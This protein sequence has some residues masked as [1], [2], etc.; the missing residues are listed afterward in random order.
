MWVATGVFGIDVDVVPL[1]YY[2]AIGCSITLL[3]VVAELCLSYFVW[4]HPTIHQVSIQLVNGH[5]IRPTFKK[6]S[7]FHVL[8]IPALHCPFNFCAWYL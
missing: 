4:A 1:S 6:L 7:I 2:I 3:V 8:C 5:N